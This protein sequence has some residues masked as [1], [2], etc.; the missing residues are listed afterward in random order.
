MERRS[1]E[2]HEPSYTADEIASL[3]ITRVQFRQD[4][5]FCLLSDGKMLCV[6]LAISPALEAAPR[7]A[8]YQWQIIADG[9]AAVWHTKGTVGVPTERLDLGSIL[10][11]PEAYIIGLPAQ[12]R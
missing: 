1:S 12:R 3:R 7:Q 11:H 10:T 4:Y 6:P 5:I 8:R 9:K 2:R